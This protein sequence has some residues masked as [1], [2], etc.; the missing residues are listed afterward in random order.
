VS[1]PLIDGDVLYVRASWSG[2]MLGSAAWI[3]PVLVAA[4][5]IVLGA[6]AALPWPA[7]LGVAAVAIGLGAA[8]A[9]R[10]WRH[11]GIRLTPTAIRFE[12]L[13]SSDEM[14]WD[15]V[16]AV[17]LPYTN[18]RNGQGHVAIVVP[19]SGRR[20]SPGYVP[21]LE[22]AGSALVRGYIAQQVPKVCVDPEEPWQ[23]RFGEWHGNLLDFDPEE[24]IRSVR[25][26]AVGPLVV[27]I[28]A[29]SNGFRAVTSDHTGQSVRE[30]ATFPDLAAATA[31]AL[32][33]IELARDHA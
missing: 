6:A 23:D 24:S 15:D 11:L 19:V 18:G 10:S 29:S 16:I 9:V 7:R 33:H 4:G 2:R 3:A 21:P 22:G 1:G 27:R 25:R 12:R 28:E 13:F 32:K 30:S 8:V 31:E 14:S 5:L 26:A 17:K 20:V